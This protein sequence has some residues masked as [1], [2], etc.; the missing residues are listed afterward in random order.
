MT[1]NPKQQTM[2]SQ[3]YVYKGATKRSITQRSKSNDFGNPTAMENLLQIL[4]KT[5]RS[6]TGALSNHF[7]CCT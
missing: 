3:S 1:N 7:L 5:T 6:R 4:I 2:P